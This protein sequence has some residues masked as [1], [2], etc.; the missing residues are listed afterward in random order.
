MTLRS[1]RERAFQ[2]ICF[3]AGGLIVAAPL[4]ALVTGSTGDESLAVVLALSAAVMLW[5]P[6]HNTAWDW[7]EFRRTGRVASD[8]PQAQRVLH[9]LSHEVTSLVV[10]LPL[11]MWMGGHDMRTAL[12]LDLGL[13]V[14]YAGYAYVF[15]IVY[16]RLRPLPAPLAGRP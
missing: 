13:T 8:R 1:P 7:V 11:L 15:H 5:S 10:T 12:L 3:E 16:D 14:F 6:L 9:A 4:Y 2:T